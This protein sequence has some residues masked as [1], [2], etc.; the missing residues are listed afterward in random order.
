MIVA[1]IV[2]AIALVFVGVKGTKKTR[3][4]VFVPTAALAVIGGVMTVV[5]GQADYFSYYLVAS[6]FLGFV[7]GMGILAVREQRAKKTGSNV[8]LWQTGAGFGGLSIETIFKKRFWVVSLV[9]IAL[10]TFVLAI[11]FGGIVEILLAKYTVVVPQAEAQHES[12]PLADQRDDGALAI[13]ELLEHTSSEPD[14][15]V[16]E[17]EEEEEEEEEVVE[18]EPVDDPTLCVQSSLSAKLVGTM[19]NEMGDWS[20]GLVQDQTRNRT[21]LV[22]AGDEVAGAMITRV[23][24]GKMWVDRDGREECLN[25]GVDPAAEAPDNPRETASARSRSNSSQDEDEGGQTPV[26]PSGDSTPTA[27][28]SGGSVDF[29]AGVNRISSTQ[30]EIQRSTIDAAMNNQQALQAQAPE[31]RQSF[32]NG[33]PNGIQITSMPRGSI[34]SRIGVRRG[35]IVMQVNGQRITTPQ[36]AMDLYDAMQ[37]EAH[38]EVVVQRRGRQR[39][40]VYD[41]R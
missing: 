41:I 9:L 15:P 29:E 23:D 3:V 11:G 10:I 17:E 26:R 25:A 4:T 19:T 8:P 37:N 27:A 24:R 7:V 18:A 22:G 14:P 21:V 28:S 38:V 2:V 5:V 33:Q 16:V 39:T 6:V 31:F 20:F 36:R 35:D 40:I 32:D 1:V 34:F 30:Y 12:D 13:G